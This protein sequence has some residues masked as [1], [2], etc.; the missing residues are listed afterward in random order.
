MKRM[1]MV[2]AAVV[3]LGLGAVRTAFADPDL[4]LVSGAD[5]IFWDGMAAP[6]CSVSGVVTPCTTFGTVGTTGSA[7]AGAE[8]LS[9]SPFGAASFN[10][11]KITQSSGGTNSPGCSGQQ[12]NG[13]DCINE[14]NVNANTVSGAT[15]PLDAYFG[16]SGFTQEQT[17]VVSESGSAAK[18]TAKAAGYAFTG[19][20]GPSWAGSMVPVLPA[21]DRIGSTLSVK[22]CMPCQ[23]GPTS[24]AAPAALFSLAIKDTF[25]G[26]QGDSFNVDTTI[27]AVPEPTSVVLFGSVLLLA[28]VFAKKKFVR[29]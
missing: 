24:D 28:A 4:V 13:P 23:D 19:G 11:W 9:V 14:D 22:N 21:A 3:L 8:T 26:A 6:V 17:L 27:G 18:G 20:L 29:S 25:S 10:G 12:F 15:D 2:V 16:S 1:I 5:E 7:G